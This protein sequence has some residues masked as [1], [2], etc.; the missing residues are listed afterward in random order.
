MGTTWRVMLTIG[1]FVPA[2]ADTGNVSECRYT[3]PASLLLRGCARYHTV[4]GG[5]CGY[6]VHTTDWSDN[7]NTTVGPADLAAINGTYNR[8]VLSS[9]ASAIV[10]AH[11]TSEPM[12]MYLAFQVCY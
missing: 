6:D 2:C 3:N 12:Y 5:S 11:N 10:Q 9:R 1:E 7:V 8:D 4:P